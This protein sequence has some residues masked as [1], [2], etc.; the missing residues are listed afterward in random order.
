M[1]PPL[2][3][4]ASKQLIK[5]DP[6][7]IN[8]MASTRETETLR[9][10]VELAM[11]RLQTLQ[12]GLEHRLM[13]LNNNQT[14]SGE[15]R[16]FLIEVVHEAPVMQGFAYN[17]QKAYDETLERDRKEIHTVMDRM[18]ADAN[19]ALEALDKQWPGLA[20]KPGFEPTHVAAPTHSTQNHMH[21]AGPFSTIEKSI[22]QP[23]AHNEHSDGFVGHPFY[24]AAKPV[25]QSDPRSDAMFADAYYQH[26]LALDACMKQKN[27]IDGFF[28]NT[29]LPASTRFNQHMSHEHPFN[30]S[31]TDRFVRGSRQGPS[32]QQH[33][34]PLS[35]GSIKKENFDGDGDHG[36]RPPSPPLAMD[37]DF[38]RRANTLE[39]HPGNPFVGQRSDSGPAQGGMPVSTPQQVFYC[40]T[41]EQE[42]ERGRDLVRK[43]Q[44]IEEKVALFKHKVAE[45]DAADQEFATFHTG[46]TTPHEI[47]QTF[48]K[49]AA[50]L[51]STGALYPSVA[52]VPGVPS[53]QEAANDRASSGDQGGTVVEGDDAFKGGQ[54]GS[55]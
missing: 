20:S 18:K 31:P 3:P 47:A 5:E 4:H 29:A 23:M 25:D 34:S 50:Q 32:S 12:E 52:Q 49:L 8:N 44:Y 15:L 41:V 14:P 53:D 28:A 17:E 43:A 27:D 33:L 10:W 38:K 1:G 21:V 6:E 7:V 40:R 9:Q 39:E 16:K 36:D 19:K 46:G 24:P 13:E 55:A 22:D 35:K 37:V 2:T 54:G 45:L 42:I 30:S 48:K 26:M 51:H 11:P